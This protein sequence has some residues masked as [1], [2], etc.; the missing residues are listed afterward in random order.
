MKKV[1]SCG[2]VSILVFVSIEGTPHRR[3]IGRWARSISTNASLTL[4]FSFPWLGPLPT[5]VYGE[6]IF[7][8]GLDHRSREDSDHRVRVTQTSARAYTPVFRKFATASAT[9]AARHWTMEPKATTEPWRA[10]GFSRAVR[11]SLKLPNEVPKIGLLSHSR[12]QYP[13]FDAGIDNYFRY[14]DGQTSYLDCQRSV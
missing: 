6:H 2:A 14:N 10:R 8:E 4:L 1:C 11:S 7:F 13:R 12:V 9:S 3:F 5:P